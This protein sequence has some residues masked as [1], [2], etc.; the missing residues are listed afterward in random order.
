MNL[1]FDF[2]NVSLDGLRG[3]LERMTARINTVWK[4]EHKDDGSH[5]TVTADSVT[6]AELHAQEQLLV[7]P[8]DLVEA[9][10]QSS[11][12]SRMYW[13]VTP[14]DTG[15]SDTRTQIR[16]RST[17]DR[18]VRTTYTAKGISTGGLGTG[19]LIESSMTKALTGVHPSMVTLEVTG[20]TIGG[21]GSTVLISAAIYVVSPGTGATTNYAIYVGSGPSQFAEVQVDGDILPEF[22]GTYNLGSASLSFAH[23]YGGQWVGT[24]ITPPVLTV[25][26]NNY[27]PTGLSTCSSIVLEASTPVNITGLAAQ[28]VGTRIR[29]VADTANA[30]TLVHE[31]ASSTATNRFFMGDGANFVMG[32]GDVAD[33]TYSAIGSGRWVMVHS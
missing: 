22:A 28:P 20:P 27:T 12:D 23:T 33:L 6:A 4:K 21:T 14:E 7:S 17:G 16:A 19:E 32:I 9:D 13:A 15:F 3:V 31:S 5:S 30:I 26:V 11:T 25:S 2:R 10:L 1:G 24:E 29:L 18:V 8:F